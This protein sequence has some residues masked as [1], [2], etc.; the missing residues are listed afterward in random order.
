MAFRI[1]VLAG[2]G[3]LINE[4]R[5][6]RNGLFSLCSQERCLPGTVSAAA[7]NRSGR[8]LAEHASAEPA[9]ASSAHAAASCTGELYILWQRER[10]EDG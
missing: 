5:T 8:Q 10:T 9:A 6:K 2:D 1:L 3:R 7:R 4:T